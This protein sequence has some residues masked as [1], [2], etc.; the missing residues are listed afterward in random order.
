MK[1]AL[2]K[3]SKKTKQYEI[4]IIK[5]YKIKNSNNKALTVTEIVKLCNMITTDP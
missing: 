1:T 2:V 3:S 5:I 4:Y